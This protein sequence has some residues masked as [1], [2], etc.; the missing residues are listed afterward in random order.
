MVQ[1]LWQSNN[2][3]AT[4]YITIKTNGKK[5]LCVFAED[6]QKKN[7][8]YAN[9]EVIVDGTRTIFI[10]FPISPKNVTIGAINMVDFND[11]DIEMSFDIQPLKQYA[12]WM[13]EQTREFVNL[14]LPFCQISGF[15]N[16]APN[17]T[18]YT[19]KQGNIN[20]K[21]FPVIKDKGKP[22]S[23]PARIGHNTGVIEVAQYCFDKYTI[24]M[25]FMILCHEY[26]HKY[27]NPKM[28]LDISNEF[29]ADLNGLYIYLGMGF[30]KIDAICVFANVF[31]KAQTDQNI[32]RMRKI[33]EY[34]DRFERQEYAKLV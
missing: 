12:T 3:T 7:S 18:L 25:R 1:H 19:S 4:I 22:I 11:K 23:T 6:L 32:Y 10:S 24:P 20:I 5:K 15:V 30:S 26:S 27:R 16:P 31:L 8:Y 21:Y 33:N 34:I 28:N 29:G 14:A 13:D 17:G 9:R 2:E